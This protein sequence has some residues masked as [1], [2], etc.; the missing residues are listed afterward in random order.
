MPS[1]CR[2]TQNGHNADLLNRLLASWSVLGCG[3]DACHLEIND[4]RRHVIV[5]RAAPSVWKSDDRVTATDLASVSPGRGIGIFA[6]SRVARRADK[7][8][9]HLEGIGR[10]ARRAAPSSDRIANTSRRHVMPVG[11]N[12]DTIWAQTILLF[13]KLLIL[14]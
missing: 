13:Y 12:S 2:A 5:Y 1:V 4:P 14:K 10:E 11:G 3:N 7:T 8:G 6:M 9:N